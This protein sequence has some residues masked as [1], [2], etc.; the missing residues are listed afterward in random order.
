MGTCAAHRCRTPTLLVLG[1]SDLRCPAEQSEQFYAVLRA[2]GC[3]AEMLRLPNSS[4]TGAIVGQ[5]PVR[6]AQNEALL[7]WMRRYVLPRRTEAAAEP[8]TAR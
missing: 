3:A 8:A 4:H 1:E 2:N 6:T 7:D 5:V